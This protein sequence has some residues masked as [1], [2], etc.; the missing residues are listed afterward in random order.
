MAAEATQPWAILRGR[1][2]RVNGFGPSTSTLARWR[3]TTELH[4]LRQRLGPRILRRCRAGVKLRG[5]QRLPG[6]GFDDL[7]EAQ[8]DRPVA[9][10]VEHGAAGP[11]AHVV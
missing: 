6:C 8:G 4:P 7:L 10:V 1:L 5:R 2:E 3:S 11:E 9:V